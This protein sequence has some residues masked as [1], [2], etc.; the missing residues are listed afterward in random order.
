MPGEDAGPTVPRPAGPRREMG[1]G[2]IIIFGAD[3]KER[4]AT[5]AR[6]SALVSRLWA[7]FGLNKCRDGLFLLLAGKQLYDWQTNTI[8]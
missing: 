5:H 7:R 8:G 1:V 3:K 2:E 6:A 4:V